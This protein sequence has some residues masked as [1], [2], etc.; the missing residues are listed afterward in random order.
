MA[1]RKIGTGTTSLLLA[2]LA[3]IW[4]AQWDAGTSISGLGISTLG[5]LGLG[6]PVL[7]N[8]IILYLF[9][10]IFTIPA[11]IIGRKYK[12]NWGT[13]TAY[14]LSMAYASICLLM[15]IAIILFNLKSYLLT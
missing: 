10:Y 2:L 6:N 3:I 13:K 8:T 9:C 4:G 14:T 15:F 5:F 11:I 7:S 12:D 1:E